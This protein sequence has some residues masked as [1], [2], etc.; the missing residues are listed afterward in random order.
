M[1]RTVLVCAVLDEPRKM[2]VVAAPLALVTPT[3]LALSL[4]AVVSWLV[5]VDA[6]LVAAPSATGA[7]KLNVTVLPAG[8]VYPSA[9]NANVTAELPGLS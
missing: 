8:L 5:A 3:A 1:A 9:P 6:T 4:I 7:G 2:A